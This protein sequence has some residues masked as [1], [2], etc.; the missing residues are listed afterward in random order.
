[1]S[2]FF[3]IKKS[4]LLSRTCV[5][6]TQAHTEMHASPAPTSHC[7]GRQARALPWLQGGERMGLAVGTQEPGEL[8]EVPQVDWW[9]WTRAVST[10]LS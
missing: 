10:L 3:V 5:N 4:C 7:S 9:E 6:T 8:I 1:M 2:S